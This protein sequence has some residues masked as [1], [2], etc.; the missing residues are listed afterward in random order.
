MK[1]Y[2]LHVDRVAG[3]RRVVRQI[4]LCWPAGMILGFVIWHNDISTDLSGA[5]AWMVPIA[6]AVFGAMAALPLWFL[7]RVFRFAFPR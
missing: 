1:T 7:Y 6:L 2:S 3:S 4:L 5:E